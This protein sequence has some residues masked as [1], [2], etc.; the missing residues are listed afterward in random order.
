[1]AKLHLKDIICLAYLHLVLAF[2]FLFR[3]N[4]DQWEIHSLLHVL[5]IGVI[6]LITLL[7]TLRQRK[8][9]LFI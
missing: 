5:V 2:I 8:P 9:W 6:L 1:M 4:I 3:N 7:K